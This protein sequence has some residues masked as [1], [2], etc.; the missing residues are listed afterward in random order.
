LRITDTMNLLRTCTATVTVQ[1]SLPPTVICQAGTLSKILDG[2]GHV[3]VSVAEIESSS[4][5]NCAVTTKEL[6]KDGSTF[7][8]SLSYDCS[9]QGA[10]TVTLRVKDAAGNPATCTRQINI[11]DNTNPTVTCLAGTLGKSLDGTGHATVSVAEIESTSSDNCGV[12]IKE[13][14][15]DGVTFSASLS[16]DCSEQGTHT[17]TLRVKD[18]AGNPATCTR[19][20]NIVDNTNPTVTCQAGTLSKLLDGSGLATVS[21]TE[22]EGSSSDNCGVTVKELSKD[23]VTFAASLSYDCSEQGTHTVTL[24]VKDAAGNLAICTRQVSVVDNTNP[25]VDCQAGTQSKVLDGTGHATVSVAEIESSSSD[26]CAVTVKELSKDGVTFSAALSY[27][28]SEQ[29]THTVTLRVKDA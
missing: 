29:G 24:R 17:V 21:V 28:C 19:Q 10:H 15:K 18:A 12:T 20:V 4:A 3:T 9:E 6:S 22:I 16:Y 23:G 14:S 26:N 2:T 11:A 13:L 7:S 8:A 5:D 25:T 27:D 1:D